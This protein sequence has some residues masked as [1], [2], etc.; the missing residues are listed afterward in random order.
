M[1]FWKE[2]P[3]QIGSALIA[4]LMLSKMAS[5]AQKAGKLQLADE[6]VAN[7][8]LVIITHRFK[9]LNLSWLVR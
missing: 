6:L 4:S 5:K 1:I 8:G 2:C 9:P 7:A 3:D